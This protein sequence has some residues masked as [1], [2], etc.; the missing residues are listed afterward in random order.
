M[1]SLV[2]FMCLLISNIYYSSKVI[3]SF[4]TKNETGFDYQIFYTSSPS[5]HFSGEK[6]VRQWT[7]KGYHIL[8]FEL[9]T[10]RLERLRID[11]GNYPGKVSISHINVKGSKLKVLG[12]FNKFVPRYISGYKNNGVSLEIESHENDPQI[13]YREPLHIH[14][15]LHVNNL[16]LLLSFVFC[17][18]AYWLLKRGF[19]AYL[20]LYTP[21]ILLSMMHYKSLFTKVSAKYSDDVSWRFVCDFIS[22]NSFIFIILAALLGLFF[23]WRK[24]RILAIIAIIVL[25]LILSIDYVVIDNLDARF[26]FSEVMTQGKE[27]DTAWEMLKKY[28]TTELGWWNA[29]FMANIIFIF[30]YF[31]H[32]SKKIALSFLVIIGLSY[33]NIHIAYDKG[34][35]NYMYYNV[36]DVNFKNHQAVK[37][38]EEAIK[39]LQSIVDTSVECVKGLNTRKNVILIIAESLSSYKIKSFKGLEDK[40]PKLDAIAHQGISYKNFYSNSYNTT[41]GIFSILTG[42]TMINDYFGLGNYHASSY[43]NETLPKRLAKYGYFTEFFTGIDLAH[44]M[45]VLLKYSGFAELSISDDPFYNGKERIIFNSVADNVLFDNVL[46]HLKTEN[47]KRPFLYVVSTITTHGPYIDP[48]TKERSFDKT[49]AFLDNELDRFINNLKQTDFFENGMVIITGD[50]HAMLPVSNEEYKQYGV[51]GD[52]AIPLII[53][54]YATENENKE[55]YNIYSQTDIAPSLEYYLTEKGCFNKFQRN[56]FD[57]DYHDNVCLIHSYLSPKDKVEVYCSEEKHADIYL[58]GDKTTISD[59][60]LSAYKDYVLYLRTQPM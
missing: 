34:I 46:T 25:S 12:D 32:T 20:F 23:L 10:Y 7:G 1:L 24:L 49:L 5:A 26:I 16:W 38:S 60:S 54:D 13:V 52:S 35:F 33:I 19:F 42:K 17:S 41:G 57:S 6:S 14:S 28:M 15:K 48:I 4:G 8:T 21:L 31:R 58:N 40:M 18:I 44:G 39:N 29:L 9:P 50:H 36:F 56:L 47:K 3:I 45:D 30:A 55:E 2:L 51:L 11:F 22:A 43:Y 27:F 53:I 37:H 59:E